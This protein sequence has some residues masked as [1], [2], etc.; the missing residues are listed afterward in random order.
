M[1]NNAATDARS[2]HCTFIADCASD[3]NV[4]IDQ[5]GEELQDRDQSA[6]FLFLTYG[7]AYRTKV[8]G[9]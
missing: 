8:A 1:L 5:Y 9:D 4:K 7:S 6:V 3:R 2:L